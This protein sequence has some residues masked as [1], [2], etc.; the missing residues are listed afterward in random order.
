MDVMAKRRG[1]SRVRLLHVKSN[2][3]GAL[4]WGDSIRVVDEGEERIAGGIYRYKTVTDF[5]SEWNIIVSKQ[6]EVRVPF[7]RHKYGLGT[8]AGAFF[9]LFGIYPKGDCGCPDRKKWWNW[10]MAFVPWNYWGEEDAEEN[11]EFDG[12]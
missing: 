3:F 1:D 11:N 12:T 6:K 7:L 4:H 5:L 10:L 9:A 8:V 2:V